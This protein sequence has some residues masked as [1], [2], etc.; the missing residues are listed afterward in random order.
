MPMT[1]KGVLSEAQRGLVGLLELGEQV[2]LILQFYNK[3]VEMGAGAL[4][5]TAAVMQ[6]RSLQSWFGCLTDRR[7]V[8]IGA[9]TYLS[10]A[11]GLAWADQR[12]GTAA[13]LVS[14][15]PRRGDFAALEYR[16]P[17]GE[18]MQLWYSFAFRDEA[19]RLV[20]ALGSH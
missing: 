14:R 7:L 5:G 15:R 13:R 1:K 17:S 8:F 2:E 4:G 12:T 19:S 10:R 6:N 18:V 11:Q 3:P 16:R 20:A 9:S